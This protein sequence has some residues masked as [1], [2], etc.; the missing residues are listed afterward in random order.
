LQALGIGGGSIRTALEIRNIG[1]P[2]TIKG[3]PSVTLLNAAGGSLPEYVAHGNGSP[4]TVTL[5][6][7]QP[8]VPPNGSAA[9]ANVAILGTNMTSSYQPCPSARQEQPASIRVTLPGS[10]TFT[11]ANIGGSIGIPFSSCDGRIEVQPVQHGT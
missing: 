8:P 2:C 9:Y 3:F 4:V 1:N 5:A 6:G 7:H 11:A 10:I